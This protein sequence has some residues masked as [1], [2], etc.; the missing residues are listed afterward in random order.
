MID[1]H[2]KW[3]KKTKAAD[4]CWSPL[5][6][7]GH[8]AYAATINSIE[9]TY[10]WMGIKQ[11][12]WEF[13]KICIHC[14]V[15]RNGEWVSHPLVGAS[16]KGKPNEVVQADFLYIEPAEKRELKYVS[17]ITGDVSSYTWLCSCK[18]ENRGTGV[19]ALSKWISCLGGMNLFTKD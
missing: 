1:L 10:S 6:W 9:V 16:H 12:K 19:V 13:S 4:S 15:S 2:S 3:C 17:L 5:L 18:N 14:I 8:Q 7:K 11:G